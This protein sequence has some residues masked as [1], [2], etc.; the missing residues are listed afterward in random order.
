[1]LNKLPKNLFL[2]IFCFAVIGFGN[3]AS[4]INFVKSYIPI[5]LFIVSMIIAGLAWGVVYLQ[6]SRKNM[7]TQSL[8]NSQAKSAIIEKIK[9]NIL[10]GQDLTAEKI[11]QRKNTL[12]FLE[13]LFASKGAV[14]EQIEASIKD[15]QSIFMLLNNALAADI[16]AGSQQ[17]GVCTQK[18]SQ[19][20][21]SQ[22]ELMDQLFEN[23]NENEN[24]TTIQDLHNAFSENITK[25]RGYKLRKRFMQ[26]I[27]VLANINWMLVN[28]VGIGMSLYLTAEG[29]DASPTVCLVALILG[30]ISGAACAFLVTRH[31]MKSFSSTILRNYVLG[32]NKNNMNVEISRFKR[33]SFAALGMLSLSTFIVAPYIA[34][35][36]SAYWLEIAI[37]AI[38]ANLVL[39]VGLILLNRKS[40]KSLLQ[41]IDQSFKSLAPI[42]A[43]GTALGI[44][45]FNGYCEKDVAL[46]LENALNNATGNIS[47]DDQG[48]IHKI[49]ASDEFK[50]FMLALGGLTTLFAAGCFLGFFSKK[51][52]SEQ[53]AE[54]GKS[55]LNAS[56]AIK[57]LKKDFGYKLTNHPIRAYY[58]MHTLSYLLALALTTS[59]MY[60][61]FQ[62]IVSNLDFMNESSVQVIGVMVAACS[63]YLCIRMFANAFFTLL[64]LFYDGLNK[65]FNL[66]MSKKQGNQPSVKENFADSAMQEQDNKSYHVTILKEMLCNQ[67]KV[68]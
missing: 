53:A 49:I 2:F 50:Y 10:P 46:N 38:L 15:D 52:I 48:P 32:K 7:A 6:V 40:D 59:T 43:S 47:T 19:Q 29:F 55:L 37:S 3:A 63:A 28:S 30:F 27:D 36:Y 39:F 1:M 60:M 23:E 56:N 13:M 12:E 67:K 9:K 17:D 18:L 68:I 41:N 62:C 14:K 31:T 26:G 44:A 57:Y 54:D 20:E 21:L 16:S 4:S 64:N 8:V 66:E 24:K 65:S 35:I 11:E 22:Q 33:I 34:S 61:T 25:D 45:A 51:S 58:T 42:L 5:E